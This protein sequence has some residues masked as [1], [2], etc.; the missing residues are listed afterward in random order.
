MLALYSL[1]PLTTLLTL[2]FL[3]F[4]PF[5]AYPQQNDQWKAH[6]PPYLPFP[7]PEL[8]V[9]IAFSSLSHLLR[10]PIF[11]LT[12]LLQSIEDTRYATYVTALSTFLSCALHTVS[13]LLLRVCSFATLLPMVSNS[14]IAVSTK[15]P[16]FHIVWWTALGWSI[17]EATIGTAQGYQAISLYKD[18]L[19]SGGRQ[20]RA[21]SPSRDNIPSPHQG[22]DNGKGKQVAPPC[23]DPRRERNAYGA[24]SNDHAITPSTNAAISR[25]REPLLCK[26]SNLSVTTSSSF[27]SLSL[28]P[29]IAWDNPAEQG[30]VDSAE[31]ELQVQLDRDIDHLLAFRSREQL[32]ELYGMPFIVS[33][34][35]W[36]MVFY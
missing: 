15:S 4:L 31:S 13:A 19:V 30:D 24:L 23:D 2:F 3:A 12:W 32:E 8:L 17:A 5:L 34:C 6:H 22:N 28:H 33:G 7:L 26:G 20:P 9:S 10:T 14:N 18:V 1:T 11:H 21:R 25:E 36:T 29:S 16:V 35:P 27:A